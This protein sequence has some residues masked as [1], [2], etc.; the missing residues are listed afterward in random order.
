MNAVNHFKTITKHRH[1]VIRNC[2]KAGILWQGLFHDLSKYSFAEFI[3][4]AKYFQGDRSPNDMERRV[5]GYSSAW[6]HHKGRNKHHF[7]YWMDYNRETRQ[8]ESVKMP[9]KYVKE[10]FCD[11]VAASRIYQGKNYSDEYPLEYFLRGKDKR[12]IHK[13]TSDILE[14]MLTIL[15]EEGRDEAFKFVRNLKEY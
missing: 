1:E 6:M 8:Y 13:E 7:E 9:V 10:M 2:K 11:R 14:K 5:K 3:Q 15:K 12:I 4:G